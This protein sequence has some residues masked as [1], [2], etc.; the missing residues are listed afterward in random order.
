[1]IVV[2]ATFS[3]KPEARDQALATFARMRQATEAEPGNNA[4]LFTADLDDPNGF[5]L[6]EE[7]E[8]EEALLEHFATPH[9]AEFVGA[10]GGVLAGDMPTIRYDVSS[11]GPL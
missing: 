1:M 8:T 7:W 11:S 5:H 6:F 10:L 2:K 9:M 3:V 4:Y